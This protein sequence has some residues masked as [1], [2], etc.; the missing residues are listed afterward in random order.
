[1]RGITQNATLCVGTEEIIDGIIHKI[2]S[3]ATHLS[4]P[5]HDRSP[6][7]VLVPPPRTVRRMLQSLTRPIQV[8]ECRVNSPDRPRRCHF[9]RQFINTRRAAGFGSLA[10]TYVLLA[11]PSPRPWSRFSPR[12]Y[13]S[14][15]LLIRPP[16]PPTKGHLRS[17]GLSHIADSKS[18]LQPHQRR[19][20]ALY[21]AA[22]GSK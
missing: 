1:M 20:L 22:L 7:L 6:R 13:V 21:G 14:G 9:S 16:L 17:P 19:P 15:I 10:A 18:S 3:S 2:S 4:P 12:L 11:P 8:G 5:L